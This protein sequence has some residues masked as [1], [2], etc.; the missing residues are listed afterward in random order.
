MSAP[1]AES[2]SPENEAP[3]DAVVDAQESGNLT[4]ALSLERRGSE[5]PVVDSTSTPTAEAPRSVSGLPP[6]SLEAFEGPLDLLLHL[7]REHKV[8]IADIPIV[9]VTDHYLAYLKSMEAMNLSIAGE[10]IVMA[11]TLLEI[12][13]RML[14]PKAPKEEEP[15]DENGEDPRE[16]L[17]RKLQDYQ[18]YKAFCDT[19]A[20]WE[21]ERRQL[22]FRG[23][24]DYGDLYELPVAFGSQAPKL[25]VSALARLLTE[26]GVSGHDDVTA[27][28]RQKMTL[29]LSMVSLLRKVEKGG[30][31]GVLFEDCFERPLIR[32]EIIMTFLALLELL[33]QLKVAAVQVGMMTEIRVRAYDPEKDGAVAEAM[34]EEVEQPMPP[35]PPLVLKIVDGGPGSVTSMDEDGDE[36]DAEE[37]GDDDIVG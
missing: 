29:K 1:T 32:F 7:I 36:V 25:L 33:R 30:A 31:E 21:D 18:R 8:D 15:L 34:D 19:L 14:L 9:Q 12:K 3:V 4:P 22:F 6:M 5:E 16:A 37:E 20:L 27:V 28:R 2:S 26:A 23:E 24:A 35:P 10:F 13:S 17:V 11:A